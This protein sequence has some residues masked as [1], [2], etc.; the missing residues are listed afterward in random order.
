MSNTADAPLLSRVKSWQFIGLGLSGWC[1]LYSVALLTW[2]ASSTLIGNTQGGC[3]AVSMALAGVESRR[4]R[5]NT[6][7]PVEVDTIEWAGAV[8]AERLHQ[9]I[10]NFILR[11]DWRVEPCREFEKGMGFGVRG[12]NTGRTVVFET[13]RWTEP[14]IDL[15][16]VQSTEEN[17]HK[18]T[19]DLAVV[20]GVGQ[21]DEQARNFVATH[22]LQLLAG[23][24]LKDML[25][26]EMPPEKK[27]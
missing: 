2:G 5:K 16:H 4:Y 19:A 21:P 23:Q 17:R 14:V 15:A 18:A 8:S 24:E 3:F 27:I 26:S 20:V 9:V 1:T 22:P 7:Q 13:A 12:V 11:S 10:T 25:K 6:T